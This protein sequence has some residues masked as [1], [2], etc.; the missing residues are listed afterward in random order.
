[1]RYGPSTPRG[2]HPHR[3][4]FYS[5]RPLLGPEVY[6]SRLPSLCPNPPLD[7][8]PYGSQSNPKPVIHTPAQLS[9]RLCVIQRWIRAKEGGPKDAPATRSPNPSLASR[10]LAEDGENIKHRAPSRHSGLGR[11]AMASRE[12]LA[13]MRG[14]EKA[15]V[16]LCCSVSMSAHHSPS[17]PF[18]VRT[19][20][21]PFPSAIFA[22]PASWSVD[23][24]IL[25]GEHGGPFGE[26][27]VDSSLFPSLRSIANDE[28]ARVNRAFLRS[29]QR[30]LNDSR[31]QAE[32]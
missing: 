12:G 5:T 26:S 23:D 6:L 16:E 15:L 21:H 11:E 1:M 32:V 19:V 3:T 2:P 22:F 25:A 31:L 10:G 24:W 27:E 9:K 8:Q 17:S 30:L 13:A 18:I 20:S 29:F 7:H 28:A 14:E 4:S